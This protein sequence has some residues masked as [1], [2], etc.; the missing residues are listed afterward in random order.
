MSELGQQLA[1]VVGVLAACFVRPALAI[2]FLVRRKRRARARRRSPIGID[3]LRSPGH[4]LREQLDEATNEVTA[5]V[6][7]LLVIPLLLLAVFLAQGHL[8]GLQG[9]M[10]LAPIYVVLALGFVA[11]MV[12]NS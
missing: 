4:T 6:V 8:R 3:L 2:G 7:V 1:I 9:M 5:D 11:V 10:H 12:R